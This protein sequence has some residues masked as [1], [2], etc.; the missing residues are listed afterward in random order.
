MNSQ[1]L[2]EHLAKALSGIQDGTMDIEKAK[3]IGEISQVAIN[4][5]KVEVDFVRANGGGKSEFF[6]EARQISH[7]QNG[8][9]IVDAHVTTHKLAG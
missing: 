7:T 1:D 3:A 4:L 8:L 6:S 2:R 5:A 9:K